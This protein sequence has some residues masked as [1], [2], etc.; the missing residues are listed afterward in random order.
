MIYKMCK[1]HFRHVFNYQLIFD[2]LYS[3]TVQPNINKLN[4]T[5]I[6]AASLTWTDITSKPCQGYNGS[7]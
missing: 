1:L 3:P 4:D 2:M 5:L 7:A 6:Q